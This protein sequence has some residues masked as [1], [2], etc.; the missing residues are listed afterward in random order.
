MMSF[1]ARSGLSPGTSEGNAGSSVPDFSFLAFSVL[2]Y[3][4]FLYIR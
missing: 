1:P 3:F 4:P 2:F